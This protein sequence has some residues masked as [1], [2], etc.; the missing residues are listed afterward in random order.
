MMTHSPEKIYQENISRLT[1]SLTQLTRRKSMLAWMRL[2]SFLAAFGL[3]WL[4]WPQG[5]VIVLIVFVAV[6][7]LFIFFVNKDLS[8]NEAINNTS[9]LIA[10]NKQ[11]LMV[12]A[13]SFTHLPDGLSLKPADHAYANDLDIFGRASLY[14]YANTA[15]TEQGQQLFANWLL[16]AS[17]TVTIRQ[18]QEAAKELA[19]HTDWRHQLRVYGLEK[20]VTK[21]TEHN[22]TEWLKEENK[23]LHASHWKILRVV[24]PLISFTVLG[25]HL[26]EVMAAGP[27]Y[28]LM[29][30]FLALSFFITKLIMPAYTRLSRITA[31]L[32]TLSQSIR[33]I[34][35]SEFKSPLLV[36]LKKKYEGNM[37][38]ASHRIWQLKK[39]LDRLDYR[40]NPIVFVPLSIFLYWDLQQI[41]ALEKW[42]SQNQQTIGNW[43]TALA[44]IEALSTLGNLCFN[45]PAWVFPELSGKEGVLM[46][47]EMGHP[48]IP[49]S[50][51]V[52]SSF[53]TEGTAQ[54]ALITGSN[55]AGKSTFLR[56]AGINIV[57]AMMGAPVCAKKFTLSPM[58][59]MSSMRISD[60][61]EESTSTFYAELKK[62][63]EIIAAVNRKEKVYL[64][65][66]EILRGTNS[67]DRHTGS[68]ALIRQLIHHNGTG[69]IATHDLELAKL[70]AEFPN[71]I[72]NYHFD[73]QVADG[74]LYFDYKL[75]DGVCKSMNA[76]ILM[77][78]I[79][80]EL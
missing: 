53:A 37:P 38:A 55:M 52:N 49:E 22:I 71:Q 73:V 68:K 29:L 75:K 63:Q 30:L 60:N 1:I 39:I 6:M 5:W 56:S 50:K 34:E 57:L 43:Y 59:V 19:Q 78:K 74:E 64:L 79:G 32:D 10:I 7:A 72:H 12:L 77:K 47:E 26:T 51:R 20:Q 36:A 28:S 76:S 8:N 70:S 14:Q 66:D 80:I 44:E 18:R 67:A 17:D 23:F 61:L 45:H 3:A 9:Q 31:E 27:F 24:L 41:F 16:H 58:Q 15:T 69:M 33:W 48:L 21:K 2:L 35:K 4:L 13:H 62:L 25:L 46:G 54:L 65:L 40:L 11:E 42:K